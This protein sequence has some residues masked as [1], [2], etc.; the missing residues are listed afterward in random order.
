MTT[1]D[2]RAFG[3]VGFQDFYLEKTRIQRKEF[4]EVNSRQML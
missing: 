4:I 1:L 3:P 2:L